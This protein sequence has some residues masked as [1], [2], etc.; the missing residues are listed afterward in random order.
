MAGAMHSVPPSN[1]LP[2]PPVNGPADGRSASPAWTEDF[3]ASPGPAPAGPPPV[4]GAMAGSRSNSPAPGPNNVH[5]IQLDF[6]A[7]MGDELHLQAGQLVR[8]LHEYDDGWAL[9]I[10]MDRSQQGVVPRT[11]LSKYPVKPRTGP[12]RQG[13]PPPGVRGP[14]IRSPM[15]PGGVPQ[16]RP[17]SPPSGRNSPHPPGLQPANGRMSPAPRSMSPASRQMSPPHMDG[18]P[19]ARSNSNAPYMQPQRSMSPGPY[20]GG[21]Q[22]APPPEMGRPRSNSASQASNPRRGPAPGPSP[23]NPNTAPVPARKPVPGMAI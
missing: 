23:M 7:S 14:P 16:P 6:K 3:P 20:G 4:V 17:L 19:R 18:A 22:A 5:R 12:P 21:P 13:P 8:M 9:C 10:R 2:L 1:E 11:C 15:G